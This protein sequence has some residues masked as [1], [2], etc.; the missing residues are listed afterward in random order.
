[1]AIKNAM[2]LHCISKW[3]KCITLINGKKKKTVPDS[4]VYFPVREKEKESNYLIA[5]IFPLT[6]R[7]FPKE[8]IEWITLPQEK[9][10]HWFQIYDYV[11]ENCV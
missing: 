11:S 2:H 9:K 3:E 1:M 8:A 4:R 5:K 10:L 7:H 6:P